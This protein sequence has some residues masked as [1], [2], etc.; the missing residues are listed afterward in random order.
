[1][2]R[3]PRPSGRKCGSAAEHRAPPDGR[4]RRSPRRRSERPFLPFFLALPHFVRDPSRR[5]IHSLRNT[6]CHFPNRHVRIFVTFQNRHFPL[7][8]CGCVV[9]TVQIVVFRRVRRK[10]FVELQQQVALGRTIAEADG[11]P[12]LDVK[13]LQ[14]SG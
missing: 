13:V 6:K 7:A 8:A 2:V 14:L 4:Y 1:M 3:R 10:D 5:H 11:P 9:V 12:G